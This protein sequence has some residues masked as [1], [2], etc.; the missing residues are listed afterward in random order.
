MALLFMKPECE[1][2]AANAISENGDSQWRFR[3]RR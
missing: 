1:S 3:Q 2:G